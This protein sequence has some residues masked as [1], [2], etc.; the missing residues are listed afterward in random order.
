MDT[1]ILLYMGFIGCARARKFVKLK[2]KLSEMHANLYLY[3]IFILL[4]LMLLIGFT[5]SVSLKMILMQTL[6]EDQYIRILIEGI[7]TLIALL[8]IIVTITEGRRARA[9]VNK[10][11]QAEHIRNQLEF[12]SLFKSN[13][14]ARA[15]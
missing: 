13:L 8:L 6:T 15:Q 1:Y 3:F 4:S 7:S 10:D 5:I 12:Y 11:R 14:R 9:E 2:E